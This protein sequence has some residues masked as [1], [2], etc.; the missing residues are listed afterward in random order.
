MAGISINELTTYRWTFEEDVQHYVQAGAA[1][2]AVWRH[3][4]AEFGEDRGRELLA[5]CG[6]SVAGLMW[7]GGFTGSDGRSYRESV[8]DACEAIRRA[9]DLQANCLIV[10]SGARA[11]HT[12][13]HARSLLRSALSTL[14]PVAE[15]ADV[16]LAL[17]PMHPASAG[18]WTFL[19]DWDETIQWCRDFDSKNLKIVLDTYHFGQNID[20]L[21]R[22]DTFVDQLAM[23]HLGD[24][25]QAPDADRD[26]CR[27]G[28]GVVPL[29]RWIDAL[30]QAGYDGYFDVKLMG[31]EI[32][33]LD[34]DQLL[35]DS[36]RIVTGWV[37]AAV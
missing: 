24:T 27:L 32:E 2:V 21:D 29:K 15:Q 12:H 23:V 33:T 36:L 26:R 30:I 5:D 1:A 14:L 3:K 34:Y 25:R 35:C 17:E 8:E 13:N 18:Q 16:T 4:L 11:G 7:A 19:T 9:A 20:L 6:L 28:T 10:S 37:H 31:Q 22:L